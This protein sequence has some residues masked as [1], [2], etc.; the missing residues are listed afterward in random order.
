M[1]ERSPDETPLDHLTVAQWIDRSSAPTS[2][3]LFR[4]GRSVLDENRAA[5]DTDV[6][7]KPL[8]VQF[9]APG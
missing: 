2:R 3:R 7:G 9:Y 4:G 5:A 8:C 6:V 1:A